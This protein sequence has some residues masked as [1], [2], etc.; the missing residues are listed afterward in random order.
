MSTPNATITSNTKASQY[1]HD[2]KQHRIVSVFMLT[3]QFVAQPSHLFCARYLSLSRR[4]GDTYDETSQTE[5]PNYP[6]SINLEV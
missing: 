4:N 6:D 1:S 3:G 5:S 2:L